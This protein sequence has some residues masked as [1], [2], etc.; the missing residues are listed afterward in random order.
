LHNILP[1]FQKKVVDPLK[2]NKPRTA[3]VDPAKK[4][5]DFKRRAT[6]LLQEQNRLLN[7]GEHRIES[8]PEMFENNQMDYGNQEID[9][10]G[11]MFDGNYLQMDMEYDDN[12]LNFAA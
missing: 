12:A 2:P 1:L 3:I 4:S 9:M 11:G 7:K 5:Q 6:K 10:N 8:Q